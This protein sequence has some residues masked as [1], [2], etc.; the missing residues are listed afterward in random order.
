M[1]RIALALVL[2]AAAVVA[3]V[4]GSTG[5][6]PP[7]NYRLPNP[8]ALYHP[9]RLVT[10]GAVPQVAPAAA[11]GARFK[12]GAKPSPRNKLQSAMPFRPIKAPP[13]QVCYVPQR[14]DN[15]GNDQYGDC[16]TAE[17]AFKCATYVPEIFI[18]TDVVI[19]WAR[20]HGV[21]NGASLTEVLDAMQ[22]DGFQV[23][24][25]RYNSGPYSGVDYGSEATLQGAIA[26]GPVKIAIASAALP[27]G[28]GN[29][30]G[31]YSFGAHTQGQTDHCVSL[32][33]YGP[34]SWLF[35]QLGVPL[36]AGVPPTKIGYMLYTWSTIGVVD[37][38]WLLSTCDEAWVRIPSTVG[39]PPLPAPPPP[40]QPQPIPPPIPPPPVPVPPG[41]GFTGTMSYQN[42]V[43]VG[44][45]PGGVPPAPGQNLEAELKAAG[46]NPQVISDVLQ[47]IAD[48]KGKK[49]FA[50]LLAD[51]FKILSDLQA[52][53]AAEEKVPP[54]TP[55][56]PPP[57]EEVS[58]VKLLPGWTPE[59]EAARK[60]TE[61]FEEVARLI[62][63][64]KPYSHLLPPLDPALK[65]HLPVERATPPE[66]PKK[67]S[68]PPP[69]A[70]PGD[71]ALE[72]LNVLR[73]RRGLRPYVRDEGLTVA[74]RACAAHRA[75][76]L[77]FGHTQNDF[78]FLPAGSSADAAGCAAYPASYGWMSC[79][80]WDNYTYGGAAWALGRDG[81]RYMHLY[82]SNRPGGVGVAVAPQSALAPALAPAGGSCAG[83]SCGPTP[84]RGRRR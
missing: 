70:N 46:V 7:V 18:P 35:Q 50:V 60:S 57:K 66:S 78:A 13:P 14:L 30:Q 73:V 79:C 2:S 23:G 39:V 8:S 83:G 4:P 3:L 49:G 20:R 47:L 59:L 16:V 44:V 6:A 43:L 34:C 63:E 64:G 9:F 81:K 75:S 29:N 25:Q 62:R 74:A 12:T 21:L 84:A 68:P 55:V 52:A 51:V 71:D 58:D 24:S 11:N 53:Q 42:G 33:G 54:P 31:W 36:P 22:G 80:M 17:E 40:P 38:Q 28:A 27:G 10:Q 37:H 61:R 1:R 72:E 48:L 82:V 69:K 15:W 67:Q 19:Q 26:Q 41:P 45:T 56:Q 32:C 77:M 76:Y 5:A 65:K